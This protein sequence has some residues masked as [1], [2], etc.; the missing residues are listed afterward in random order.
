VARVGGQSSPAVELA[1]RLAITRVHR[2]G[3]RVR[4]T[5]RLRDVHRD[6]PRSALVVRRQGCAPTLRDVV[7]SATVSRRGGVTLTVPAPAAGDG[8]V[9]YRLH[10]GRWW[11][12]PILVG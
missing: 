8:T 10:A 11:S 12:R 2:S 3:D 4:V 5:A 1:P 7:G 6:V 9:V